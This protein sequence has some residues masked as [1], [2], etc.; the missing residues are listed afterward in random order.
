MAPTKIIILLADTMTQNYQL[1]VTG[2]VGVRTYGDHVTN[3]SYELLRV[4][5]RRAFQSNKPLN[6]IKLIQTH[7][8][9]TYPFTKVE[10]DECNTIEVTESRDTQDE[11]T[12]IDSCC[13][14]TTWYPAHHT[15]IH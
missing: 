8:V 10:I 4:N 14:R 1:T 2:W 6:I 9:P 7:E 15:I 13:V 3:Q 5:G 11:T 12:V